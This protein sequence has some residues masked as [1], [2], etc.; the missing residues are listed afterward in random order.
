[1]SN[2][3]KWLTLFFLFLTMAAVAFIIA[4]LESVWVNIAAAIGF[5]GMA[6][7]GWPVWKKTIGWPD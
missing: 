7:S 1:M 2:W 4:N 5:V 3:R 6:I